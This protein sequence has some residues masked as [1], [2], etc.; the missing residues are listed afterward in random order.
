MKNIIQGDDEHS[1][2]TPLIN[3]FC[4]SSKNFIKDNNLHQLGQQYFYFM[5]QL[6]EIVCH[7]TLHLF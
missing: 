3:K 7:G 1:T 5:I 4:N 6:L 2:F